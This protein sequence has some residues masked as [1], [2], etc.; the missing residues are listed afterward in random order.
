MKLIKN[1]LIIRKSKNNQHGVDSSDSSFYIDET[2]VSEMED[3][4]IFWSGDYAKIFGK[5]L[6]N[7]S[8]S[9]KRLSIIKISYNGHSIHRQYIARP[10]METKYVAISPRSIRMLGDFDQ[11]ESV[12]VSIEKGNLFPFYWD[13][14]DHATRLSA[15]LGL[16]SVILGVLSIVI[17][18]LS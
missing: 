11:K 15:R 7:S 5:N 18:L 1:T 14:P 16:L 2:D 3:K 6:K 4:A 13:H 8:N 12:E 17:S 9:S 10:R